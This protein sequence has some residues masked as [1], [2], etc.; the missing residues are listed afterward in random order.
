MT[1]HKDQHT[2]RPGA[3]F[4]C[5]FCPFYV[6]QKKDLLQ[7]MTLHGVNEPEDYI[8]K[9]ML[10]KTINNLDDSVSTLNS[11]KKSRKHLKFFN[12]N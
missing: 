5:Y 6:S 10:N 9:A 4:K 1:I 12:K 7:H 8:S 2:S 3:I 11:K